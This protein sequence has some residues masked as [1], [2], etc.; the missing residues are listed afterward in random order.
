MSTAKYFT[1]P[2]GTIP[3]GNTNYTMTIKHGQSPLNYDLRIMLDSGTSSS[4]S[5]NCIAGDGYLNYIAWFSNDLSF[6]T[7]M[8]TGNN[9]LT[10]WYD[11]TIGRYGYV[12]G[13]YK[14]SNN[15]INRSS[16]SANNCIGGRIGNSYWMNVDLYFACIFSTA[17]STADRLIVEAI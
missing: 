17:L 11:N 5:R 8:S 16:T 2:N 12:N 7:G 9:V 4:N 10:G 14:N 13:V 6:G 15:R 1:L 3:Y